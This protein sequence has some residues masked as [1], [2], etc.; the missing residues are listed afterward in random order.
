MTAWPWPLF[1]QLRSRTSSFPAQ[2]ASTITAGEHCFYRVRSLCEPSSWQSSRRALTKQLICFVWIRPRRDLGGQGK[3]DEDKMEHSVI[4]NTLGQT[5]MLF[6]GLSVVVARLIGRRGHKRRKALAREASG[7]VRSSRLSIRGESD[8]VEQ[9][10]N[11][12][13]RGA[14]ALIDDL[15]EALHQGRREGNVAIEAPRA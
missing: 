13:P 1:S 3:L 12:S 4:Y 9:G 15:I 5:M 8:S 6:V 11:Q 7:K 2:H 14:S 10:Q